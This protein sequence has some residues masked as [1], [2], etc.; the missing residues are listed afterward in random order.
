MKKLHEQIR[1]QIEKK[2]EEYMAKA[3]KNRKQKVFQPGDLVWL[4]LRKERFPSKR[5]NKLMPR[6]DGPFRVIKRV[7]DGANK[8]ELPGD[9][10]VSTTF[11]VGDLSPCL[12][13]DDL[14]DLRA[15]LLQP[16]EDDTGAIRV[17]TPTPNPN[18][19]LQFKKNFDSTLITWIRDQA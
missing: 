8:I 18:V 14:E 10:G 2:N 12:E 16:G 7:G 17:S 19:F 11:N 9:Y 4:H 3:N 5:K 13:E 6:A 15:N 1:A